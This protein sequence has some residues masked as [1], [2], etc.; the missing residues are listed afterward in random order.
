MLIQLLIK[1]N[2]KTLRNTSLRSRIIIIIKKAI[3]L[4]PIPSLRKRIIQK[5]SSSFNDFYISD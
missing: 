1:Q 5:T 2:L 3:M 4:R